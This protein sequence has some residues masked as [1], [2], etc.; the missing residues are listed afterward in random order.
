MKEPDVEGVARH[1]G[2]EPC[3][4][5]GNDIVEALDWGMHEHGIELRDQSISVR[6]NEFETGRVRI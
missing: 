6:V 4:D 2:P 3:G 5:A 1:D